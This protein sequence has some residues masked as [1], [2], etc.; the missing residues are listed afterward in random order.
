M[1]TSTQ[2][3]E[4]TRDCHACRGR[5]R[6]RF[7][8]PL[9]WPCLSKPS[10]LPHVQA[11]RNRPLPHLWL[12]TYPI[13]PVKTRFEKSRKASGCAS[14]VSD[15][16]LPSVLRCSWWRVVG[17][18]AFYDLMCCFPFLCVR[19]LFFPLVPM[20]LPGVYYCCRCCP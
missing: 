5:R 7:P 16:L 19:V 1:Q 8:A 14:P 20:Y 12:Q 17:S 3:A 11:C 10:S 6:G 15:V 4:P 18:H 2:C 9:P 13:Q